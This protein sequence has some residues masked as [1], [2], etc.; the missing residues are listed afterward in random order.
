M[1]NKMNTVTITTPT[2]GCRNV[3]LNGEK[4]KYQITIE[5][6]CHLY[7]IAD[8]ESGKTYWIG[9]LQKCKT[10]AAKWLTK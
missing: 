10:T 3:M 8:T 6:S 2:A 4:T 5:S 7:G 9:S 1:E